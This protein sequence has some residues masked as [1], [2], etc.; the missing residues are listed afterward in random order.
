MNDIIKEYLNARVSI[1]HQIWMAW[2]RG[3]K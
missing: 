2:S 3:K 1:E